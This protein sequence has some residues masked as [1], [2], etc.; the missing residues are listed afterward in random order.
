MDFSLHPCEYFTKG[1]IKAMTLSLSVLVVIEMLNALNAL[2]EDNSLFVMPPWINPWL[3]LAILSS[4]LSHCI[5]LYIPFL[6]TVF[7]TLPLN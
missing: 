2:S 3:I 4:I 5:I 6:N 7:G 1:K